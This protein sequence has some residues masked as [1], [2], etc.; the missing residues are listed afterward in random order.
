[1]KEEEL[2]F[3][4]AHLVELPATA[5]RL[6]RR[7]ILQER[8]KREAEASAMAQGSSD[9]STVPKVEA[10]ALLQTARRAAVGKRKANELDSSYSGRSMEPA[11]RPPV[12]GKTPGAGSAP[13]PTQAKEDPTQAR[14]NPRA[15]N[16]R[17]AGGNSATLR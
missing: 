6:I 15:N 8:R 1:M 13:L 4:K 5:L 17:L 10:P 7:D 12:R 3:L 11:K 16:P 14:R 9:R 2:A